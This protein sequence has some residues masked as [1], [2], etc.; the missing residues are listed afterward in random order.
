MRDAG[1]RPSR[2]IERRSVSMYGK[3]VAYGGDV[4]TAHRDARPRSSRNACADEADPRCTEPV[5]ALQNGASASSRSPMAMFRTA[6]LSA[7][8]MAGRHV[9]IR[10][11]TDPQ[12]LGKL[13]A[14]ATA[15]RGDRD[16]DKRPLQRIEA[17][18]SVERSAH[19]RERRAREPALQVCPATGV[20]VNKAALDDPF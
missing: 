13:Q 8:A 17:R 11:T 2:V 6:S 15:Q 12:V 7:S 10:P 3:A 18:A 19:G 1:A 20:E 9:P 4:M 14:D 5:P 16:V